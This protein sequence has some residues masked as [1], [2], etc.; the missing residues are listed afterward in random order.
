MAMRVLAGDVGG[1]KSDLALYSVASPGR[2][3]TIRSATFPSRRYPDFQSVVREF[4][5]GDTE[6]VAAAA[7]GLPGPVVDQ[8]V[9]VTNL[10]WQVAA[11]D[12]ATMLGTG[13]VRLLNDLQATAYGCLFQPPE[14]F[15]TLNP[16]RTHRGNCAVI[17]AGTGLGEAFLFW[18]GTRHLPAA[19]EGGHADFAPRDAREWAL[20]EFLRREHAHVSYEHVVSGPGLHNVF[21]Y[22]TEVEQR[23]IAP[24]IRDQLGGGDPSAAIGQA[25][26]AGTCATA[27][28][29]VDLFLGVY[30]AQAGNLALTT[31]ALGGVFVGGGVVVKL[32]PR[33][34]DGA[35]MRG[36]AAK[37][38][39]AGFMNDVPVRVV[40]DPAT[41][42]LGAA[43]AAA[44]L[45]S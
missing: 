14:A 9:N 11:A 13:H 20:H 32:L 36:F 35:F 15:Q 37:G 7:F 4:L 22:L 44:D 5:A 19:T 39:F 40:L 34:V 42:R 29:A 45:L 18:D 21:R 23:P 27:V 30:G 10:P 33:V 1:T 3:T 8:V 17:A 43:H 25:A 16:G 41:S 2:L 6:P 31:M 24:A 28:E 12:L 38:R 26:V